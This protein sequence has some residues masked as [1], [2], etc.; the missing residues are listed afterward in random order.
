M[1]RLWVHDIDVRAEAV[2]ALPA[3]LERWPVSGPTV[4]RA[5]LARTR[6]EVGAQ[7]AG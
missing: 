5:G 4:R 1:K 2:R 6:V 7:P 3:D